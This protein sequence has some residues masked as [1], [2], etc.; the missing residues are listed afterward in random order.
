MSG[1]KLAKKFSPILV[2][3]KEPVNTGRKV[4]FPKPVEIMGAHCASN[5]WF[6][7]VEF[8]MTISA[9]SSLNRQRRTFEG[10]KVKS[11]AKYSELRKIFPGSLGS[12]ID[13]KKINLPSCQ[14]NLSMRAK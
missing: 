12:K 6:G 11:R 2:M 10:C 13:F 8:V 1:Y 9:R 7:S 14:R 5:L 3:A 4:I